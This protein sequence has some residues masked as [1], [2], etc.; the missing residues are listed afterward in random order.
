MMSTL[1]N[2]ILEKF[3]QLD[4]EGQKRVRA[5]I[6]STPTDTFDYDQWFQDIEGIRQEIRAQH[7]GQL[8]T[9]NVV[10]I[11]RDIRDGEDE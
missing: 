8:P 4:A 1:E 6:A 9:V 5:A 11:L 2:E 7:G 3:R 10:D